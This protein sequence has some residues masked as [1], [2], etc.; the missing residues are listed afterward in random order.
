MKKTVAL[1]SGGIGYEREVSLKG[2]DFLLSVIDRS[3]YGVIDIVIE[4]NGDWLLLDRDRRIPVYPV[5][6]DGKSGFFDG[7]TV[8]GVDCAMPMLHGDFGEDG[9]IQGALEVA[10]IK[11]VGCKTLSGSLAA[12]KIL[13]KIV[14]E[15][16]GIPTLPWVMRCD[17]ARGVCAA[18]RIAEKT[19]GYPMFIKPSGLGSSVGAI[20]CPRGEG[21]ESAYR[22]A[23]SFSDRI[24]IEKMLTDKRELEVGV[25]IAN[26]EEIITHPAEV[27][28]EGF[29]SY[30]EKYLNKRT[31]LV[32][33]AEIDKMTAESIKAY[34][35]MLVDA[36]S[37][38]H[39]SRIDF[40]LSDGKL[41]L[42]EINTMP[43]FTGDSLYPVLMS[44]YGV[45]PSEL[46]SRL[47]LDAIEK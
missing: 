31:R 10:G 16:L 46:L 37:L 18:R 41:Y 36:L 19:L 40:F 11:F 25:L 13:T 20:P 23:A 6:L 44:E 8:I 42:N 38:R 26:G 24:L 45:S 17:G 33:R 5:R 32:P 15:R 22:F 7:K 9:R 14:A 47:F 3:K 21:F 39:L 2:R 34:S 4:K 35:K 12:D 43:G 29:Y 28:L 27:V 30:E 1:I